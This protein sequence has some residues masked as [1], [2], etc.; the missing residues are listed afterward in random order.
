M[1]PS[2]TGAACSRRRTSA[3]RTSR[4][5]RPRSPAWSTSQAWKDT[6]AQRQWTDLYQPAAEFATFL[7]E[8]RV[9]MQGILTD[10]GLAK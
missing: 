9:T 4:R 7:K 6:V 2:S 5:S 1:S 3:P 8:D 10:L